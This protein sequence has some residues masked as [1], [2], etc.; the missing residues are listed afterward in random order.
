MR[1]KEGSF[2][3]QKSMNLTDCEMISKVFFINILDLYKGRVQVSPKI[4]EL[5]FFSSKAYCW[6]HPGGES[7]YTVF[8]YCPRLCCVCT[9]VKNRDALRIELYSKYLFSFYWC[10]RVK[11]CFVIPKNPWK[12]KFVQQLKVR[13]MCY[14]VKTGWFS[15]INCFS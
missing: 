6:N 8:K 4:I 13:F 15:Q 1:N 12:N 3:V 14:N 2:T 10:N 11:F 5:R 7:H 9:I